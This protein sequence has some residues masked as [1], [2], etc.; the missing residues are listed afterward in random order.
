MNKKFRLSDLWVSFDETPDST[1][2]SP[3][4]ISGIGEDDEVTLCPSEEPTHSP[5]FSSVSWKGEI[6]KLAPKQRIIIASL[7]AA[8]KNGTP[9]VCGAY[10]VEK[11]DSEQ[12]RVSFIFRDTY[13]WRRLILPG[14]LSGGPPDTY[15]LAFAIKR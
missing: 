3:T 7:W 13:A 10:L 4:V 11:A 15:C 9:H 5:C 12:S 6:Y 14:E 8:W 2:R 1:K